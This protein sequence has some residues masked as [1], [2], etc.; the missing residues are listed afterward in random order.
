MSI[1]PFEFLPDGG[2]AVYGFLHRP[3]RPSGDAIVLAHGAGSDC[4]SP[5]LVALATAFADGAILAL[6]CD[7]PFRQARPQ[8]PPSR[9]TAARDREGLGQAVRGL[10]QRATGRIFVG[11][12]SYGG[13]QGS[14]LLADD[15][16]AASGLLLLSYPL[17]PPRRPAD[18]R[19]AHFTGLRAPTLFVHGRRDPFG[20]IEEIEAA[21]ARV[22][23]PTG[24]LAVDGGHDLGCV[25]NAAAL[26]ALA[27]RIARAF[28]DLAR[29]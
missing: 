16:R 11:G 7:L 12:H 26:P 3:T 15:P 17:H 8:G 21:R 29:A 28:L 6:R 25:R 1:E 9:A 2:P 13:R 27:R 18:L 4:D 19:T 5:L 24:L 22:S 23:A 14:M 20:T 10:R